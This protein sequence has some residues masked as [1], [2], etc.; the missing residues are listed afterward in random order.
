M[1]NTFYYYYLFIFKFFIEAE[2]LD[3]PIGRPLGLEQSPEGLL[4]STLRGLVFPKPV[5]SWVVYCSLLTPDNKRWG[6]KINQLV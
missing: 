4:L 1:Y 6:D 2:A 3:A 5:L